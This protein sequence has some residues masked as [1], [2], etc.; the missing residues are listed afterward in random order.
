MNTT[1]IWR[2]I[3]SPDFDDAYLRMEV[4]PYVELMQTGSRVS[5]T[6]HVG[7]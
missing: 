3:S 2:I 4:E 1:G 5:G 6:Y 7:L